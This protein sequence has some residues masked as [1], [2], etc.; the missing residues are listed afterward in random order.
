MQE[1]P[2]VLWNFNN[3]TNEWINQWVSESGVCKAPLASEP[4]E[5]KI[6]T[7]TWPQNVVK[8]KNSAFKCEISISTAHE[9]LEWP[10]NIMSH[11][12]TP[13]NGLFNIVNKKWR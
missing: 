9:S 7:T 4:M 13:K 6:N 3:D 10:T 1:K 11:R 8:T 5:L 12:R 2:S